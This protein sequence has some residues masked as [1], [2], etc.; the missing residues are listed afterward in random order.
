MAE[1][2]VG[3]AH[4]AVSNMKLASGVAPVP[5]MLGAG[6]AVGLGTDGAASNNNLSMFKEMN[7]AALLQKV[8]RLEPTAMDARETVKTAT[9]GG[10]KV[11]GL[12]KRIGSLETGKRADLI[13]IDLNSPHLVPLYN[14]Y[15]Q[16]VYATN[17]ADVETVIIDGRIVMQDRKLLTLDEESVMQEARKLALNI[18]ERKK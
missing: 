12:N 18:A 14:V 4:C 6:I 10:A 5:E 1:K 8:S 13:I 16:L 15:S 9:I 7:A 11:L 3:V 17:G 2:Q